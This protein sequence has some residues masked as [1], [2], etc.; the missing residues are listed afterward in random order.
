MIPA[1]D[2]HIA[3]NAAFLAAQAAEPVTMPHLLTAARIE[4]TARIELMKQDRLLNERDF[5]WHEE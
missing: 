1:I 5:I 3:L 2:D 4:L